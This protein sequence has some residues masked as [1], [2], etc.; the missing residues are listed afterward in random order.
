[1]SRST[2]TSRGDQRNFEGNWN[3][4]L[5]VLLHPDLASY[6]PSAGFL[7]ASAL[8]MKAKSCSENSG[9]YDYTSLH[10]RQ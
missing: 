2:C 8:K 3:N 9:F 10:S 4:D 6:L 5:A 1:M 7:L